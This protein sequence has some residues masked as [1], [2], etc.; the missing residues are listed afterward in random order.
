MAAS[1][2]FDT[3]VDGLN[4]VLRAFRN[5][6][7]EATQEL[8]QASATIADKYMAPA[9][10]E[11]AIT[12]AGPW[13]EEIA[14][15]VRVRRDRVPAVNIGGARKKFSGGASPTMVRYLSDK[16]DQGRAGARNRA[17]KA[18]GSGTDW[19][20]NVKEKYAPQATQEWA[21][22]V[23]RIVMKWSTL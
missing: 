4:D 7:K 3:Y 20:G 22:A 14:A 23:D 2:T 10:R 5:L 18:F 8:R 9:W 13:G 6:P 15:S 21:R 11:A 12:F 19:M 1:K 17:P 16:G